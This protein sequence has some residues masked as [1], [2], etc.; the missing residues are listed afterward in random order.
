M[1]A[2]G[3]FFL[4]HL[5][6]EFGV[7]LTHSLSFFSFL[8]L[9]ERENEPE[10]EDKRRQRQKQRHSSHLHT[11]PHTNSVRVLDSERERRRAL[12]VRSLGAYL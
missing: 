5:V 4:T 2:E 6:H 8:S 11:V 3:F 12:Q 1:N 9:T 7:P 10:A